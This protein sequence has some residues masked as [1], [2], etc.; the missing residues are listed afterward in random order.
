MLYPIS[1]VQ[2]QASIHEIRI[3]DQINHGLVM[4]QAR[5][6]CFPHPRDRN[7]SGTRYTLFNDPLIEGLH[8]SRKLDF[9]AV[10]LRT[11]LSASIT[12]R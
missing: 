9:S 6:I 1:D 5:R 2:D 4:T 11:D 8:M 10:G 3:S 12:Y 7:V